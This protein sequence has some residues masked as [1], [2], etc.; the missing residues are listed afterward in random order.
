MTSLLD[1]PERL[2]KVIA[3]MDAGD[4]GSIPA[5]HLLSQALARE[6]KS[7]SS[8]LGSKIG[9]ASEQPIRAAGNDNSARNSSA[10]SDKQ[11]DFQQWMDGIDRMFAAAMK[12]AK[13]QQIVQG[14][15]IPAQVRGIITIRDERTTRAGQ[16]MLIVG[17]ENSA[18]LY[19]SIAV[20]DIDLITGIKSGEILSGTGFVRAP[21][22]NHLYPVLTG[23]EEAQAAA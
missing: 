12:P 21:K 1:S 8:L 14:A 2:A 4:D 18:T 23:F 13:Q 11:N 6:G 9:G 17:I 10:R 19:D 20:F 15:S 22:S 16:P 3:R 5:F 7:W